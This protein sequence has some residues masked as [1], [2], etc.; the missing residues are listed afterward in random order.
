MLPPFQF[1]DF[2]AVMGD[3]PAVGQHTD[4]ILR[5]AGYAAAEIGRLREAGVLG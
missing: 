2:E 1:A 3:V 4:V 5:E